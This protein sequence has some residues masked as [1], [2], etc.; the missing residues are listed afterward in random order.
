MWNEIR[1]PV[2]TSLTPWMPALSSMPEVRPAGGRGRAG[3][4]RGHAGDRLPAGVADVEQHPGRRLVADLDHVGP[5]AAGDERGDRALHVVVQRGR[6]IGD[7]GVPLPGDRHALLARVGP[8][9][10]HVEVDEQAHPRVLDQLAERDGVGDVVVAAR[11]VVAVGRLRIDEGAQTD[12]VEAVGL[13]RREQVVDRRRSSWL[14]IGDVGAEEVARQRAPRAAGPGRAASPLGT[15]CAAGACRTAGR[16]GARC[17]TGAVSL[18]RS[19]WRPLRHRC[20]SR[21][22]W[23]PRR[24]SPSR[25]PPPPPPPLAPPVAEAPPSPVSVP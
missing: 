1:I 24:R 18:R 14:L 7:V 13:H 5:R 11:L 4:L 16:L 2:S 12:E 25:Q 19:P 10:A 20:R 6:E 22:L 17:A 23:L 9:V 21:R 3:D 15:R 8:V